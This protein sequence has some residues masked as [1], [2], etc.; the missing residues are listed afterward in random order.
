MK[1]FLC[2]QER[3]TVHCLQLDSM[4]NVNMSKLKFKFSISRKLLRKMS[5]RQRSRIMSEI[6]R[7]I[8]LQNY[9]KANIIIEKSNN[10][11]NIQS[12]ASEFIAGCSNVINNPINYVCA[13][14]HKILILIATSLLLFLLLHLFLL[15]L[16]SIM[17]MLINFHF[18]VNV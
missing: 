9:S 15:M 4:E 16:I 2:V 13:T 17:T 3:N 18:F 6:R 14:G 12:T 11:E 1:N 5:T 8:R 10:E 7:N